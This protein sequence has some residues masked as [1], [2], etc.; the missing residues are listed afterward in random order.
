MKIAIIGQSAFGADVLNALRENGHQIVVVYTIPD[1]NGREDLLAL[2]ANK[3]GIPVQKPARWRKKG[4]D[5]KLH[6]IPEMLEEYRKHGAELN[7]LPFCTQFIPIEII[8][9]P[10]Y[11]SI[12][13]HPSILPAHRGAS[14]IN[15]T[16]IN[17]DETAGFTVFW[18]DDGLDTGPILLQKSVKVDENDTLNS[19]YKRFLYPEGVKG[20]AEAVELIANGKAPRIVQ[21]E[22]GASYEPY[23][24]AKPELAELNWSKNQREMHN[25]IRGNDKVPGAWLKLNGE[26]VTLFGSSIY[27]SSSMPADAIEVSVND[28]PNG[29]VFVHSKGLLLPASD[30]KYVNVE[31]VKLPDGRTIPGSKYGSEEEQHEKLVLND[32]EKKVEQQLREIWQGILK[33]DI[34]ETTDFFESGA[35]SQDVTR[36]IEETRFRTKAE[37]ENTQV[38]MSPSFGLYVEAVVRK[39]RG[40]DEIKLVFDSINIHIN[41]MDI[42]F[43]HQMYIDGKF[44]DS[45]SGRTYETINPTN[46]KAICS[47]PKADAKDVDIAVRAAKRAFEEGEWG[48][49]SARDR[50]KLLFRLADLMEQHKEELATIESIDSGAVY[51][52]ALKTHVGMSIDVWRY[53]AG[54]TDKIE[55]RSIPISNARPNQNLCITVREPIGV[56]GIITPWNYPLMMLSWKMSACLAAGNTVVLKPAQVCPLTALKFA[57]LTAKAGIPPGVVNIVTGSGSEIGQALSN[58]PL[59]RKIGFTGSTEVGAQVMSSCACSNIKKVSLELGGK[60]PLIIF[61]DADLDRAVKQACNAVFF[62]KGE[63]CIAA[64]RIFL[65][66]SIHDD[67]V[68][69]MIAETK[70]MVIGDPLDR[71]TSHGPQNHRAHLL[72]LVDYVKKGIEDGCRIALGGHHINREGLFFEPTILV[73]V[74]DNNFVAKEESFGPVMVVSK[75]PDDDIEGVLKRAN[76]TEYGLAAGVFSKDISKVLRVA[77]RLQAG[78]VFVNTYQKTDVAAPFGG[79]KQSGFGKDLGA[80]ALNEYLHTK[81]IT[82]E[83]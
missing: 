1:K 59:V 57:E 65:A 45:V 48:R 49:M 47:V 51:T 41:D 7:V 11:K 68:Q 69:R 29:K 32:E 23:I 72:K 24:T 27:K 50:G 3:L 58:H 76:A 77:Q 73:D 78:T 70:K 9:Q 34:E 16:L 5:G 30:L 4:A 28:C 18:A 40:E 83:Y 52:L 12:I 33:I 61:A 54:W 44:V 31:T 21:P 60:S 63:N 55:G 64:G 14:A 8:E 39:L 71:A 53:F 37:L 56:C 15:W 81:T 25:F 67:F 79:Y 26:K 36:L 13:Y 62:N 38:Y 2:E 82:F 43:P 22:K 19:L 46:E 17:G 80:E 74:D 42:S 66:E 10:K 20:M 35:T 75:F 6:L